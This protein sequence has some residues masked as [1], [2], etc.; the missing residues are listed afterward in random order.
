MKTFKRVVVFGLAGLALLILGVYLA[1]KITLPPNKI[2]E[3]IREHGSAALG[4]EV[5]VGS[6]GFG[7]FPSLHVNVYDLHVANAPGFSGEPLIRLR[8]IGLSLDLFSL[9][10]LEPVIQEI[11]L[12]KPE[13]LYEVDARGRDN[14]EG[15]GGVKKA[16][17]DS[18]PEA[19]A[20]PTQLPSAL[21]L[22]SFVIEDGRVR[23]RDAQKGT[24]FTLGR[25]NQRVSLELD[26]F[27]R[28][29]VT[30]GKLAIEELSISDS[31]S[32]VRK[33]GVSIS[34]S[35]DVR[36]DLP[37]QV[38]EVKSVNVAFQDIR[39][40]LSG[41]LTKFQTPAPDADLRLQ[42]DS[43]ALASVLREIPE[44]LSSDLPKLSLGG[45]A[46]LDLK[47][48]GVLDSN[49]LQAVELDFRLHDVAASHAD[50]PAGLSDLNL[51]AQLR[52]L[53]FTLEKLAFKVGE[54]PVSVEAKVSDLLAIPLLEKLV[55]AARI[56]LEPTLA[57]AQKLGM[58]D[59]A[60]QASGLIAADIRAEGRL[61]V[62]H[63]EN[64]KAEGRIDLEKIR[65][66]LPGKPE[67]RADG[68]VEI[69]NER[70]AQSLALGL[71]ESD[72][73]AESKVTNYLAL[74]MPTQFPGTRA[75]VV[76]KVTSKNLELDPWLPPPSD[77]PQPES[78][79]LEEYPLIPPVDAQ[80]DVALDRTVLMGL[81]I[82]QFVLQAKT[83]DKDIV[84]DLKGRLY[85]GSFSGNLAL[86]PRSRTDMGIDLA[87]KLNKVE[88]N[89]F[90]SRLNDRL[91][92]TSPL[93]RALGKADSMLFGKFD[94]D[95]A[96]GTHGLPAD[97]L[98]NLSGTLFLAVLQGKLVQTGLVSGLSSAAAKVSPSLG[99]G[100]LSFDKFDGDFL[101]DDGKLFVKSVDIDKTPVGSLFLD[102]AVGFDNSLDLKL[103]Q[104][105]T[106]GLSKAVSGAGSALA[107]QVGSLAG[108]SGLEQVSLLPTDAQGRNLLYFLVDGT[109]SQPRFSLDAK[110]MASEGAAGGVKKAAEAALKKKVDEAKALAQAK[111]DSLE[112]VARQK[113][114]AEKEKAKKEA[115]K[116]VDEGKK[117][118]TEEAKK[119]GKKVL[120]GL[121][122]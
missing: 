48:N 16:E 57:L 94:M 26:P 55:V 65:A 27:L 73:K 54:N 82:A 8:E 62:Q 79:P 53:T 9:F 20:Q 24:E 58:A 59:K 4:R 3:L 104:T 98:N 118:A 14:L 50:L 32:G 96:M 114:E 63:P 5:T 69:S 15:L 47:I 64:L 33:G 17:A 60:L 45:W 113:L 117:K 13:I 56:D 92:A 116:V 52:A 25:I 77:E 103:T 39:A 88:A 66:Q 35:H 71:G 87:A 121:G 95:M 43:V 74:L 61:D 36:L 19:E 122:L 110:R 12:E 80:I 120:K 29:V 108:I 93:T 23:F 111:K 67:I 22:K 40:E 99:F 41:T 46:A 6:I 42:A 90:L 112:A 75:K 2:R 1:V 21:A 84:T 30:T 38:L 102:G 107:K 18:V 28:N 101:V 68:Q 76:A 119:Q 83:R 72:L 70:I 37:G 11:R 7:V 34:V 44:G 89:D 85:S 97:F 100:D 115:E 81:E 106:P 78:P 91:P 109:V 51:V 10:R 31:A 105:L 49:A 86:E